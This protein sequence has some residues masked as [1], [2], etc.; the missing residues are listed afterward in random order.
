MSHTRL[1]I[2][3][4]AQTIF[5]AKKLVKPLAVSA[6]MYT[7]ALAIEQGWL[8]EWPNGADCKSA[9]FRLR[10]FESITTHENAE[11]AQLVE[12]NLAKVGVASSSLVFRSLNYWNAEQ[13]KRR[14]GALV[15]LVRIHACHAWGHEFESRTHRQR[16]EKR[17]PEAHCP[18]TSLFLC[19][20]RRLI[21]PCPRLPAGCPRWWRPS[22]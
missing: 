7:F 4:T 22:R 11:I 10:W 20:D 19:L 9:G 6:K 5:V 15:Q 14:V 21:P 8:P 2:P 12:H 16:R 1:I 13:R 17:S 3:P 18:G